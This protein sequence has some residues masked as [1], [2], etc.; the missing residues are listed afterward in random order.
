LKT[1][2]PNRES[3]VDPRCAEHLI[4]IIQGRL[5]DAARI[6]AK[7]GQV[8]YTCE[9]LAAVVN[10]SISGVRILRELDRIIARRGNLR[11]VV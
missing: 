5:S 11:M 2:R 1:T 10:V 6:R 7:Q 8:E 3:A 9:G 4:R